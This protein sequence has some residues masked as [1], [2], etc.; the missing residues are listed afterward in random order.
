MSPKRWISFVP[1]T[2]SKRDEP[3]HYYEARKVRKS[4]IVMFREQK[5]RKFQKNGIVSNQSY[6]YES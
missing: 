5:V 1:L 3:L 6:F 2:S 4:R